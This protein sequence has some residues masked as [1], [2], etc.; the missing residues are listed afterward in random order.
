M[1][2]PAD[3]AAPLVVLFD[4]VCNLCNASVTWIIK[5]DKQARIRFAPL[6]S[7]TGRRMMAQ[8]HLPPDDLGSLVLIE[9][10][11]A[12]RESTAALRV[13][14]AL[15]FPWPL[16]SVCLLLPRCLRDP[17]YRL[18]ARNRHRLVPR[19]TTCPLP[20]AEWRDRFLPLS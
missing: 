12:F 20:S 10:G 18:I 17:V 3:P 6:Q 13:A 4:G 1:P 7:A 19:D 14:R 16:L 15:R 11:R 9:D 8:H 5:R 2:A